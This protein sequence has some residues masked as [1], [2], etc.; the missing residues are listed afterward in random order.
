[1]AEESPHTLLDHPANLHDHA[2]RSHMLPRHIWHAAVS[3]LKQPLKTYHKRL[4]VET[5][6]SL[7]F[8][9]YVS[10]PCFLT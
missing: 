9:S 1:M 10:S 2:P 6:L 5:A 4:T 8:S 7:L 3:I